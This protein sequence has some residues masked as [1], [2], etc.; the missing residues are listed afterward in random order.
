MV[1]IC[2]E[3]A[4]LHFSFSYK[5][6]RQ[7]ENTPVYFSCTAGPSRSRSGRYYN[8]SVHRQ[9]HRGSL[10]FCPS[11]TVPQCRNMA[12]DFALLVLQSFGDLLADAALHPILN[13]T[14]V[15]HDKAQT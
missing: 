13:P 12:C 10:L 6:S 15:K 2:T 4:L 14:E 9:R 1:S 8:P 3:A 7:V 5:D 11:L